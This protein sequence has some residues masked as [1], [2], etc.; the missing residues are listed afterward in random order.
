MARKFFSWILIVLSS[1]FL[2]LTV[3]GIGAAWYYN[4]PLTRQTT[5]QLKEID[6]ELLQAQTTLESTQAELERAL[7]IVDAAEK[8]L[9][10]LSQQSTDAKSLF[11]NIQSTLDDKLLPEL[12]T[13]RGRIDTART[14]L[15]SWQSAL[16]EVSSFIPSLDLNGLDQILTNLIDSAKS[17]DS[18]IAHVEDVAR[19]ASTFVSDT[20]YLLG[21]DMTETRTSL[22]NFLAAV[23]EYQ[24]KVTDW[25]A[26]VADLNKAL[27]AWIDRAS[28][29]LTVF[30]L[31]FGFSQFGLLLHGLN[32]RR[33]GD[34]LEVLRRSP[35]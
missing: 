28:I 4:E 18:E 35:K 12:K 32:I 30:L 7:R 34:P 20:S 1:I 24:R 33:G 3:I 10:K 21:G 8:A 6:D 23:K 19:Q 11:D 31:W 13:T 16:K 2:L 22:E 29:S 26:Q 5:N 17:L 9:E 27:P 14:T 15:E 25:R